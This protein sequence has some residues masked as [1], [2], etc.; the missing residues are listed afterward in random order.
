MPEPAP[1]VSD[2]RARERILTALQAVVETVGGSVEIVNTSQRIVDAVLAG[3]DFV[4]VTLYLLS[5]DGQTLEFEAAAGAGDLEAVPTRA[6]RGASIPWEAIRFTKIASVRD[7]RDL[8]QLLPETRHFME[9]NRIRGFAVVPMYFHGRVVGILG[10]NDHGPVELDPEL[11]KVLLALGTTAAA[12]LMSNRFIG[13]IARE[14][15]ER[16]RAEAELRESE[17]RLRAIMESV[18]GFF[19]LIDLESGKLLFL[20]PNFERITGH[21]PEPLLEDVRAALEIVHPDDRDRVATRMEL[22]GARRTTTAEYR[23][24]TS[25]G[26]VRELLQQSTLIPGDGHVPPRLAGIAQDVTERRELERRLQHVAKMDA[27]GRLAGGIAHDF[28]NLLTVISGFAGLLQDEVDPAGSAQGHV[29]EVLRATGSAA[30]LIRRLLALVQRR[31]VELEPVDLVEI[32]LGLAPVLRSLLGET[33]EF[34]IEVAGKEM[35]PGLEDRGEGGRGEQRP[36]VPC[37]YADAGQLEQVLVNLTLNARDAM[38]EG[39]SFRLSIGTAGPDRVVL[40][41]R[42]GGA[43][44][45]PEVLKHV[46]EPFFSTK[47]PGSGTGLGLSNV[48]EIVE[49][50][51]GRVRLE[52]HPGVGTRVS[53]E[54]RVAERKPRSSPVPQPTPA[55]SGATILLVDDQEDVRRTVKRMLERRGFRVIEAAGSAEALTRFEAAYEAEGPVDLVVSDTVMPGMGGPELIAALRR[56]RPELPA[57]LISGHAEGPDAGER[58]PGDWF[59]AK[60]FDTRRLAEVVSQALAGGAASG[61]AVV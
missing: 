47:A 54:L 31:Q 6:K 22:E 15:E 51:G 42:D 39:G 26:E 56:L 44:M 43:G 8:E 60:P 32:V 14:A 59:L 28:N 55:A 7:H 46:F 11:E 57:V 23:M 48:R 20:S 25:D 33:V 2:L 45:A 1:P 4:A 49:Q 16:S 9:R 40:D 52:S 19:F 36:S 27:V 50:A 12:A 30:V 34:A 41:V 17:A 21:S 38:P 10:L 24:L 18:D 35:D 13:T 53:V 3:T 37:V 5:E 58:G 61:G 29:D